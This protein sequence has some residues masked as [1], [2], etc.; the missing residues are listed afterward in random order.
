MLS[1]P[2]QGSVS[3]VL[4]IHA[5]HAG[6]AGTAQTHAWHPILHNPLDDS[7]IAVQAQT[8]R[9]AIVGAFACKPTETKAPVEESGVC[10]SDAHQQPAGRMPM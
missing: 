3:T 8:V 5:H 7:H 4:E 2:T 10:G 6:G 9:G 1:R